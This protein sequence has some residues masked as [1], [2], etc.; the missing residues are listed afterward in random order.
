[1]SGFVLTLSCTRAEAEAL[2]E[3]GEIFP[4]L[5]DPPTLL[6][7]EPDP[8]RPDDW[9]LSAYFDSEPSDAL[10]AR[11]RALAP[12]ATAHSLEPLPDNDWLT[13][14]QRDLEPVRAGRFI[15]H[16]AAHAGAVRPGDIA[17][18]V[19]AGLAFGTGQH[20]TTHGCLQALAALARQRQ[21]RNIID[22]GTGTGILAIAAARRWPRARVTASDIDPLAVAVAQDN[23]RRNRIAP[24]GII[25]VTA[26]GMRHR[27][28]EQRAPYDL[29]LANI[30]AG[31][32]IAMARPVSAGLA[33][34]GMLVLAG[35][36]SSQAAAVRRA[37]RLHGLVPAA[38]GPRQSFRA[39]WPCLVLTRP[40]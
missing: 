31:P 7:D 8:H 23:A 2:P 16:T 40:V 13:L 36:L 21:F 38:L 39:E 9:V 37:Y 32:L 20:M 29:M 5:S 33:P 3:S 17:I 30:L 24:G 22:L 12:S 28:I 27:L 11:V 6:V 15:A 34:G 1:M 35:L 18:A 14:S 25:M 26:A 10:V 4:D 19:E